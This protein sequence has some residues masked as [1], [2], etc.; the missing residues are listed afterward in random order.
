MTILFCGGE[1]DDFVSS[2]VAATTSAATFRSAYARCSLLI[3]GSTWPTYNA[4]AAFAASSDFSVSARVYFGAGFSAGQPFLWLATG[5]STRLRIRATSTVNSFATTTIYLDSYTSG[6]VATTLQTST[7]T[8]TNSTLYRF[9]LIVS[10]GVSGRVR[11]Y[12]DQVLYLDYSGDVTASGS[13]TLNEVYFGS[14]STS[15]FTANISEVIVCT[16]D[17][18]TLSLATLAPN[19]AGTTNTFT[20]GAY[21][22]IDETTASDTDVAISSTTGQIL[23]V[24]CTGMPTGWSN[25]SVVAVKNLASAAKGAT[26]PSK[27]AIGVRTGGTDYYETATALDGGYTNPPFKIWEL[28]P[29]TGVAW[30]TTEIDALQLAYKSE[31]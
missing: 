9:D 5:G 25:L 13:T 7:L 30:T 22:D 8:I 4:K 31:T 16:Q 23:Q 20:S 10:Y 21:T 28:N 11:L 2:G 26:G 1:L 24:N 15:T 3:S 12:I 19:A 27:L 14:V 17:S 6:G 29:V 18:R